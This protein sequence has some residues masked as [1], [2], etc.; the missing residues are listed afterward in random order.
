MTVIPYETSEHFQSGVS[1]PR[2]LAEL[3]I[4]IITLT[5]R[6]AL[7]LPSDFFSRNQL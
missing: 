6:M 2:Q 1:N 4:K 5:V 3:I 7:E